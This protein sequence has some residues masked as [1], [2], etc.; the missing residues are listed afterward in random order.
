M[1]IDEAGEDGA[2][3]AVDHS[4]RRVA[5]LADVGDRSSLDEDVPANELAA[6]ILCD[7]PSAPQKEGHLL[8]PNRASRKKIA[9]DDLRVCYTRE[10][11]RAACADHTIVFQDRPHRHVFTAIRR[12]TESTLA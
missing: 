10:K 3:R 1:R 5:D 4:V 7:D 9:G 2:V 6:G 8:R 12:A 11:R